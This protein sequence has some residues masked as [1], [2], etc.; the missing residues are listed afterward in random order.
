M[1]ATFPVP[2]PRNGMSSEVDV[3]IVAYANSAPGF[4]G[5]LKQRC[6]RGGGG[7][8]GSGQPGLENGVSVQRNCS[9][10]ASPF[11]TKGWSRCRMELV[12]RLWWSRNVVDP[13]ARRHSFR[14]GGATMVSPLRATLPLP[15]SPSQV[16]RFYST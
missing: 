4:R 8:G 13:L 15:H 5:I 14:L 16:C 3:G 9:L 11:G 1:L 10:L 2:H 7:L 12:F 6:E